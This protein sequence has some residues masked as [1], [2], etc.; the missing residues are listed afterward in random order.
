MKK[1]GRKFV[2]NYIKDINKKLK[3]YKRKYLGIKVSY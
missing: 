3:I 2:V 1:I